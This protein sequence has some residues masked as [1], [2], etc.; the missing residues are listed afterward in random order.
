MTC[1]LHTIV[2]REP[3]NFFIW[4]TFTKKPL[5][6]QPRTILDLSRTIENIAV[7]RSIKVVVWD[8]YIDM[9]KIKVLARWESVSFKTFSDRS[10]L[11]ETL[12]QLTKHF[13]F[14]VLFCTFNPSINW[15][16]TKCLG[17]TCYVDRGGST[18]PFSTSI[19]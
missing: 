15:A 6:F 1:S 17:G 2:A 10:R 16:L 13:W 7:F 18:E 8:S 3:L 19:F 9:G 4:I 5:M 14:Q 12:A 11:T